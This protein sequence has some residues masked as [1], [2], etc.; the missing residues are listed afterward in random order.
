MKIYKIPHTELM[1]SRIAYGCGLVAT[2]V[3][4]IYSVA[5]LMPSSAGTLMCLERTPRNSCTAKGS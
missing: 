1:V 4:K 5:S 2:R 3:G